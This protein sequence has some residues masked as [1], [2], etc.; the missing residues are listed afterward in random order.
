[1]VCQ[2]VYFLSWIYDCE[3]HIVISLLSSQSVTNFI[4]HW[5]FDFCEAILALFYGTIAFG[6]MSTKAKWKVLTFSCAFWGDL[7][8][9]SGISVLPNQYDPPL[10]SLFHSPYYIKTFKELASYTLL[11][12]DSVICAVYYS[13]HESVKSCTLPTTYGMSVIEVPCS[14]K[15]WRGKF[16][17]FWC[18]PARPSKF[19][20]S[21]CLKTVQHLIIIVLCR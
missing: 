21:N 3:V 18:F 14:T 2:F 10:V 20:L 15:F 6:Q 9:S 8:I 1:M 11:Q 12:E 17:H 13:W 7:V 19:N 5:L 4:L 16:W